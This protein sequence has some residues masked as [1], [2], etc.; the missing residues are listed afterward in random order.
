MFPVSPNVNVPD[1]LLGSPLDTDVSLL[2]YIEA[3]PRTINFWKRKDQ[4]IMSG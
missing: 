3:F 4:V 2:C 1:Q